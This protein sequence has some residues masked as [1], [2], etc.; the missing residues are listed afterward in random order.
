MS[1]YRMIL[2]EL[3]LTDQLCNHIHTKS[4]WSLRDAISSKWLGKLVPKLGQIYWKNNVIVLPIHKKNATVCI[5]NHFLGLC[6]AEFN[7]SQRNTGENDLSSSSPWR[8]KEYI[9]KEGY[10]Y[11]VKNNTFF[12]TFRSLIVCHNI[13]DVWYL[14]CL[15]FVFIGKHW[16]V[17]T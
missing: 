1:S 9:V 8:K 11:H 3:F 16:N 7:K 6:W 17:C 13:S 15:P 12:C 5:P 2:K 10:K 14:P 4:R